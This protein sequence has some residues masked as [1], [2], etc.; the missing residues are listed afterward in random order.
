VNERR[1]I[2]GK[3]KSNVLNLHE[4]R[5]WEGSEK[6]ATAEAGQNLFL[7][8]KIYGARGGGENQT[9][10]PFMKPPIPRAK[11]GENKKGGKGIPVSVG[12][13]SKSVHYPSPRK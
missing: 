9:A 2:Q 1:G 6:I 13:N 5:C 12:K 11:R 3:P 8:G 4:R 7:R 10:H